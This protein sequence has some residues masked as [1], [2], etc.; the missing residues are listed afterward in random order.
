MHGFDVNWPAVLCAAVAKFAIGGV[1]YS[2]PVFGPRWGAIVGVTPDAFKAR[3]VQSMVTDLVASFVLA[4]V[5]ANVLKFTGAVGLVPGARVSFFLW[6]G[7]VATPLLSTT[8]YEG[9]PIALFGIN[10]AYWLISMLL[11]GGLIGAWQ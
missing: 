2:P 1:W 6:L 3:M 10:A 9:R 8:V 4:W 7:F 11:M 5:L